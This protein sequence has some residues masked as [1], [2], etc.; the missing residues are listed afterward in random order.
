MATLCLGSALLLCC[1]VWAVLRLGAGFPHYGRGS[2]DL[3]LPPNVYLFR[4]AESRRKSE[5]L[6]L[7]LPIHVTGQDV[8][9]EAF[10]EDTRTRNIS[11]FGA[12][13]FLNRQLKPG[14]EIVIN[15]QNKSQRAT[16]RVVYEMERREGTHLYGVVFA[17]PNA[18]VWAVRDL[19]TE[20]LA[21]PQPR[22]P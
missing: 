11:G 12:S 6:Y 5:R 1:G 8:R 19:L 13:V 16:C 15:R 4:Q 7:V 14:Q 3:A 21:V 9:G 17:D 22:N 20:A 18:D 10:E 2:V